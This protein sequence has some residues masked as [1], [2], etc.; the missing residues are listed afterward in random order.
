MPITAA[1]TASL[2]RSRPG[3]GTAPRRQC[4]RLRAP[5]SVMVCG[6]EIDVLAGLDPAVTGAS[7]HQRDV[8]RFG[9]REQ[10][11]DDCGFAAIRR[12]SDA[13]TC[14]ASSSG[15]LPMRSTAPVRKSCRAPTYSRRSSV[16]RS[17]SASSSSAR[18]AASCRPGSATSP[19]EEPPVAVDEHDRHHA[20]QH[21][22][23]DRADRVGRRRA[24]RLVQ[25]DP[26]ERD[27]DADERRRVLEEHGAHGRVAGRQDVLEQVLVRRL[28]ARLACREAWK[29]DTPSSTRADGQD[30]VG[31]AEVAWPARGGP[32]PEMPCVIDTPAP[33][34]NRP[35][36]ANSD[37]T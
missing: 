17:T 35:M 23:E 3:R 20:E 12:S 33:T 34:A 28:A 1:G 21:A 14:D 9:Q 7:W 24:G 25:P 30:G 10:R 15:M 11:A 27:G 37:H 5:R 31:D 18:S 22:D 32:A 19:D 13:S 26:G 16:T 2:S 4:S 29:N 6:P 36:A 8:L